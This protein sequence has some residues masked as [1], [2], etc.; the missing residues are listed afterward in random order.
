M[1]ITKEDIWQV[2]N[3]ISKSGKNPTLAAIRQAV[4]SGSFTTISEAMKEW[5]E[6]NVAQNAVSS[7]PV[8]EPVRNAIDNLGKQLWDLAIT[9]AEGRW[10]IEKDELESKVISLE[11]QL[12]ESG[13]LAD[14]L[15]D[16]AERTPKLINENEG[17]KEELEKLKAHVVNI[18]N[19][20]KALQN[21]LMH[22]RAEAGKIQNEAADAN[23][24]LAAISIQIEQNIAEKKEIV[25]ENKTLAN[26]AAKTS[27]LLDQQ[28]E[29]NIELQQEI[30]R[31]QK[32][33]SELAAK[34]EKIR[35]NEAQ[36]AECKQELKEA[37]NSTATAQE[38][39]ATAEGKISLLEKQVK[40]LE[41]R[42]AKAEK[43]PTKPAT[44]K[45]SVASSTKS[46]QPKPKPS[47]TDANKEKS[48]EDK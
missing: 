35:I 14:T 18:E 39:A 27:A 36:L 3:E 22:E 16:E 29:Q 38:K 40:A 33:E 17:L 45:R 48:S 10:H 19:D 31:L 4:G 43:T 44:A 34:D 7:E 8:P 37:R 30:K 6:K 20:N 1:A 28:K 26:E 5:R 13:E 12:E 23:Q 47:T 11:Q 15:A 21:D 46:R 25:S 9:H 41:T 2:A 42:L 24:K 32:L